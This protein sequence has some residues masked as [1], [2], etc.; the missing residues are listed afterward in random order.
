MPIHCPN[1]GLCQKNVLHAWN[2]ITW[3]V[4]TLLVVNIHQDTLRSLEE[5][6]EVGFFSLSTIKIKIDKLCRTQISAIKVI[7]KGQPTPAYPL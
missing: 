3:R 7:A 4:G 1:K 2:N 5:E 6:I